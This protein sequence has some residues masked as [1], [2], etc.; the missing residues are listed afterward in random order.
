MI[1]YVKS[2][3]HMIKLFYVHLAV[4]LL[5]HSLQLRLAADRNGLLSPA[6]ETKEHFLQGRS[7]TCKWG[8]YKCVWSSVAPPGDSDG[9]PETMDLRDRALG[10]DSC[11]F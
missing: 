8:P 1:Y 3:I 10:P 6:V 2:A 4:L 9:H 11:R 7:G 5:R